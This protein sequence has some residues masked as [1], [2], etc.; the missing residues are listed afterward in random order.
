MKLLIHIT[1][2]SLWRIAQQPQVP[3]GRMHACGEPGN[4]PPHLR[5]NA[6]IVHEG[7][8]SGYAYGERAFPY[9][10]EGI[11]QVTCST[12]RM[13]IDAALDSPNTL[14]W[15]LFHLPLSRSTQ[16]KHQTQHPT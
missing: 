12:C 14:R 1:E 7:F 11:T 5:W 2:Q 6:V 15:A 10:M 13:L 9:P 3:D 16:Q 8:E 4:E